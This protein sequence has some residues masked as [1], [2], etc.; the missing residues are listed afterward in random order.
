MSFKDV[1]EIVAY[2]GGGFLG[3]FVLLDSLSLLSLRGSEKIKDY[4]HLQEV[5][6]EEQIRLGLEDKN[7]RV[8][9]FG[10]K[11]EGPGVSRQSEDGPCG[12]INSFYDMFIP[13]KSSFVNRRMALR[14]EHYHIK[15]GHCD[16]AYNLGWYGWKGRIWNFIRNSF[17]D[18]PKTILHCLKSRKE[19]KF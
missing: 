17:Y 15:D 14:H 19:D 8:R 9:D 3:Y 6:K 16:S 13:S 4:E 5:A 10:Y 1:L 2:S 11:N 12:T 18:E 7:I